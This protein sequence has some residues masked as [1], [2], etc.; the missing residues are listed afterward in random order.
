MIEAAVR[1]GVAGGV[2]ASALSVPLLA[3]VE[4]WRSSRFL[5][6]GFDVNLLVLPAALAF[7]TGIVVGY[8]VNR[9]GAEQ[10][11]ALLRAREAETLRDELR[12]RADLVDAAHRC[13][14]ALGSSLV[15]EY[16][17]DAFLAELDELVPYDRVT[18]VLHDSGEARVMATAG[19]GADTVFPTGAT[20]PFE[21]TL[22]QEVMSRSEPHYQPHLSKGRFPADTAF[23]ELGLGCRLAAPLVAGDEAIGMVSLARLR[24]ESFSPSEV[25]TVGLLGRF[26]G[27]A[28]L[29]IRA[30]EELRRLSALRAD[31]VSIVSHEL[32]SPLTAVIGSSRMLRDRGDGLAPEQRR[33]LLELIVRETSRLATLIADVLDASRIDAGTF[34]YTFDEVAVDE[35]V[36]ESAAAIAAAASDVVP[37]E[38]RVDAPLP[39]VRGD[40][41]RLRQV[42]AN[43]LEN[44]V[45]YS[46]QGAAVVVRARTHDGNV[47]VDVEDA[48]PGIPL[49]QQQVIFEK[50]GRATGEAPE[51]PGTG[52][53]LFIARSIAEAH[54]GTLDVR[55]APGAG[56]VFTLSLPA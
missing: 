40:R 39:P 34:G 24:P 3:L 46:P 26:V 44:A 17:F 55:S 50:F 52:L 8:L 21:G 19:L 18:I 9:L 1:Y 13:A 37:V 4:W 51:K 54:G 23:K 35:L 27:S 14:R 25:E 45:K 31:F 32:R 7:F 28:V 12:R 42:L 47:V 30:Y 36:R 6:G 16:A 33:S 29:N 41:E 53:G 10:R 2:S 20:V 15:I 49:D 38:A 5:P 56:A 43:L 11:N 48:G 22:L